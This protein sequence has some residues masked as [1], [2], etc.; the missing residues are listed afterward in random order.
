MAANEPTEQEVFDLIVSRFR[1]LG[2]E[3]LV[4]QVE[5]VV[6]RGSFIAADEQ[7]IGKKAQLAR[8]M[9]P[10]EALAIALE[11]LLT[12][13]QVP[14]MV[15]ET[16]KT[17]ASPNIYW[18]EDVP[19]VPTPTEDKHLIQQNLPLLEEQ[20]EL[21]QSEESEPPAQGE[22]DRPISGVVPADLDMKHLEESLKTVIRLKEELRIHLPA[23]I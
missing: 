13:L 20:N 2:S 23:S 9:L 18:H 16:E 22:Q 6:E 17:L 7:E 10:D 21:L 12:T 15:Q 4:S 8:P 1:E 5:R 14:L 11:F 19:P 3:D